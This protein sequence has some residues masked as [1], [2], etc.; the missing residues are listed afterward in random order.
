M[1]YRTKEEEETM[2][3]RRIAKKLQ[4]V[5]LPFGPVFGSFFGYKVLSESGIRKIIRKERPELA[6]QNIGNM[7]FYV[8][9]IPF[10]AFTKVS[11]GKRNGY[12]ARLAARVY[13]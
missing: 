12:R 3:N 7:E 6:S 2:A 13:D 11:D 10:I 4:R 1:T 8:G 5:P 9:Q